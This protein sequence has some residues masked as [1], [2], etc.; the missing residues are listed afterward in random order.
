MLDI[1]LKQIGRLPHISEGIELLDYLTK[2]SL[3]NYKQLKYCSPELREVYVGKAQAIDE[4]KDFIINA[5]IISN[6]LMQQKTQSD[7]A[8]WAS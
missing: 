7:N 6:D 1:N 5:D 3:E 8:G 2:L 4:I